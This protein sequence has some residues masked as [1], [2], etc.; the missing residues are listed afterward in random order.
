M[1]DHKELLNKAYEYYHSKG[2]KV[3]LAGGFTKRCKCDLHI[4]DL[5]PAEFLNLI[6]NSLAVIS[7]SFHATAFSHIFHK[8]FYSII[9]EKKWGK[10]YK[11][12]TAIRIRKKH[13]K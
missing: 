13:F 6:Y 4:K 5:G 8:K 12:I 1:S 10:N 7:S 11:S 9:P 2:I 3:V